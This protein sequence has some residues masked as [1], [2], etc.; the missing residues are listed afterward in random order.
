MSKPKSLSGATRKSSEQS[1]RGRKK[2]PDKDR[3][4]CVAFSLAP[5]A[6]ERLQ[7]EAKRMGVSLSVA[8]RDIVENWLQVKEWAGRNQNEIRAK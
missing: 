7:I 8:V 4:G 5:D 1:K 3:L 6:K 2:L